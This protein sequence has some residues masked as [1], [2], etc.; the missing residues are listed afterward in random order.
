MIEPP[1]KGFE[2]CAYTNDTYNFIQTVNSK[3]LLCSG[4]CV[5][6]DLDEIR[7]RILSFKE[8]KLTSIKW[9]WKLYTLM[10]TSN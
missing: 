9:L 7:S 1:Q 3:A 5:S 8:P 6:I 4:Y 10:L 2:P